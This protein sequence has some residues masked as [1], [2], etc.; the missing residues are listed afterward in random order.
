MILI[1]DKIS[2]QHMEAIKALGFQ[3]H[4]FPKLNDKE[5]TEKVKELNPEIIV[6]R[7]RKVNGDHIKSA[8]GL[9]CVIRAGAGFDNIDVKTA[10]DKSIK[11]CNV[12]GKNSVAVSELVFGHLIALDRQIVDNKTSLTNG[13]W[14]KQ[15]LA[16]G[17]GIK[18]S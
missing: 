2:K 13:V 1:A 10:T 9:K 6:V 7:S 8:P 16:S 11:V 5:F 12:P 14:N 3:I 15:D 18:V 4:D 17:Q